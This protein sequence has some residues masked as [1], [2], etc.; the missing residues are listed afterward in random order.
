MAVGLRKIMEKNHGWKSYIIYGVHKV[1]EIIVTRDFVFVFV[2]SILLVPDCPRYLYI[3][4]K[5]KLLKLP[6]FS[7]SA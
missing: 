5:P 6:Q 3:Y 1:N 7:T 2:F 4:I